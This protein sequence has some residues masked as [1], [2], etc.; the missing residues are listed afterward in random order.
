MEMRQW[1]EF[2][3]H[4]FTIFFWLRPSVQWQ[5]SLPPRP[6]LPWSGHLDTRG[7][8]CWNGDQSEIADQM[9][10]ILSIYR[11]DTRVNF[12]LIVSCAFKLLIMNA[13]LHK[14]SEKI[15]MDILNDKW[16]WSLVDFVPPLSSLFTPELIN[17]SSPRQAHRHKLLTIS[18]LIPRFLWFLVNFSVFWLLLSSKVSLLAPPNSKGELR[19]YWSYKKCI[20]VQCKPVRTRA[21]VKFIAGNYQQ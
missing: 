10:M 1:M 7:K 3:I 18:K 14:K 15:F 11:D 6:R 8:R 12:Q 21:W 16:Q 20:I 19:I 5:P 13:I 9:K 17:L 4:W 2:F